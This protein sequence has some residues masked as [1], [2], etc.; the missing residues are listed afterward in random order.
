MFPFAPIGLLCLIFFAGRPLRGSEQHAPWVSCFSQ[1]GH[2]WEGAKTV[3]TPIIISSDGNLKAYAQIEATESGPLTCENTVR[4][5]V[6]AQNA[7]GFRQVFMQKPSPLGGTAD[8]LAPNSWS[9]NGRWLLVEFGRWFYDSDAGGLDILLYDKRNG[10]IV[11]PD[12]TQIVQTNRKQ[13]CSIMLVKI[14][15]FDALSRIHLQLADNTEE[16]DDRPTTHCFHGTEEWALNPGS[17][18]IEQISLRP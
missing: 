16:G 11:S 18:T 6:S 15:G 5:F 10:K 17:E 3:R 14:I 4:L 13:G 12:L 9:P 8:S 7:A 1:S 2:H